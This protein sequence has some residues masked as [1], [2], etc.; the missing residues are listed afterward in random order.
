MN[1]R[2]ITNIHQSKWMSNQML[3]ADIEEAWLNADL[4]RNQ[5]TDVWVGKPRATEELTVSEL[6]AEGYIGLYEY[7]GEES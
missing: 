3:D 2:W 6:K 1:Y 7:C 4:V 5:R